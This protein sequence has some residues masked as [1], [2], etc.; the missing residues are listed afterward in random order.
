MRSVCLRAKR[1]V[2]VTQLEL[3]GLESVRRSTSSSG[4]S[5]G[6]QLRELPHLPHLMA[7]RAHHVCEYCD[8]LFSNCSRQVTG[9]LAHRA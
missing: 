8:F 5:V 6:G 3:K 9:Q 2:L 4:Q 7:E 1:R